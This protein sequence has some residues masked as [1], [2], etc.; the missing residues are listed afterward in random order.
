MRLTIVGCAGSLPRPRLARRRAT[1]SST[2][3]TASC[4][5]WATARSARCSATPTCYD[6][7]ARRALTHLH[8]DHC[9]DLA[10][11]YVA[12]KYRPDGPAPVIP[13]LGPTGTAERM[14]R[15]YD[16]PAG[17]RA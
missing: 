9:L 1:S 10:S 12:R 16:L 7:D 2:T 14:A 15:A 11:Y 13:V 3:A 17:G 6:V 4:S 8:A 5:T